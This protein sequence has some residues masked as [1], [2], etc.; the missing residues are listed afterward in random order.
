MTLLMIGLLALVVAIS[1]W[2][3]YAA[4]M[5]R[6]ELEGTAYN[7]VLFVC[8]VIM[9]MGGFFQVNIIAFTFLGVIFFPEIVD[10]AMA[11]L[12]FKASYVLLAPTIIGTGIIITLDGYAQT[13]RKPSA[14]GIGASAW[15]TYAMYHNVSDAARHLPG[16]ASDAASGIGA[17]FRNKDGAKIAAIAIIFAASAVVSYL[18]FRVFYNRG[19]RAREAYIQDFLAQNRPAAA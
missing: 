6:T 5:L 3:S 4:G 10:Q 1:C 16:A 13:W 9:A 17:L 11:E 15:N 7:R 19:R 14:L 2:N 12:V 8:V 18:M